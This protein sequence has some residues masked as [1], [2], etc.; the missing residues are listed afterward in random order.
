MMRTKLIYI[1]LALI[2]GLGAGFPVSVSAQV[3]DEEVRKDL[4]SVLA[5]KGKSCDEISAISSQGEN[6]YL[7]TCSNGKRYRIKI[8]ANER[9]VIE[10]L[11]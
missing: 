11:N 10:D 3:H 6:D 8:D 7:V 5:L 1:V 9:V 4:K 2:L